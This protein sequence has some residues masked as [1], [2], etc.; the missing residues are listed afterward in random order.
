M[1]KIRTIA[2]CKENP[3]VK[4]EFITASLVG[5]REGAL[6][7]FGFMLDVHAKVQGM[8]IPSHGALQSV[9]DCDASARANLKPPV[10]GDEFRHVFSSQ[11]K[12]L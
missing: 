4:F 8:T 2:D 5:L 6:I 9:H 7:L 11:Y 10:G 12:C 1:E 3:F